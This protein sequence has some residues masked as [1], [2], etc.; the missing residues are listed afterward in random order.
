[1]A[2][3]SFP[4][5]Y[6]ATLAVLAL[7]VMVCGAPATPAPPAAQAQSTTLAAAAAPTPTAAAAMP[8]GWPKKPIVS[9]VPTNPGGGA[10]VSMRMFAPVLEKIMGTRIQVL[11]VAGAAQ[12]VGLTQLSQAK[13]DG[14]TIAVVGFPG[15]VT[16]YLDPNRKAVFNRESFSP[17]ALYAVDPSVIT[18]PAASK[19]K[20]LKDLIEAAKANPGKVKVGCAGIA[21]D[22][23]L[24]ALML[25]KLAGVK[26][27]IVQYDGTGLIKPE[28]LGGHIDA[29]FAN[30]SN[31]AAETKAGIYRTLAILSAKRSRFMPDVPTAEELGFRVYGDSSRSF[32]GPKGVPKEI[33]WATAKAIESALQDP[34]LNK[35]MEKEGFDK[36]YLNPDDFD[37]FWKDYE[38]R[39]KPLMQLVKEDAKK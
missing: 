8:A 20:T 18:V 29:T 23:H 32:A 35:Q 7:L 37:K 10:D 25:Q 39:S 33:V 5:I 6:G 17:I 24:A 14:Y 3:K 22:D 26:F 12:Q 13:N 16:L 1:M 19:Y 9:I 15:V 31:F 4:G 2:P 28:M 34:G 30:V 38:E 11:N 27:A 36:Q 21:G